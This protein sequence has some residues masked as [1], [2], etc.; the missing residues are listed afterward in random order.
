MLTLLQCALENISLA[1]PVG[2]Y[3]DFEGHGLSGARKDLGNKLLMESC[4][5]TSGG[6]M[7]AISVYNWSLNYCVLTKKGQLM[8]LNNLYSSPADASLV[9]DLTSLGLRVNG[10]LDIRSI[11]L[12]AAGAYLLIKFA[13]QEELSSWLR[14]FSEFVVVRMFF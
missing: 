7:N 14:A 11:E 2:A 13:T 10:R 5:R 1:S 9:M 12:E 6:H 8:I 3:L 4:V